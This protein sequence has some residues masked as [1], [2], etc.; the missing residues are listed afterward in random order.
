MKWTFGFYDDDD[1]IDIEYS[2]QFQSIVG[3]I[4]SYHGLKKK[5]KNKKKRKKIGFKFEDEDE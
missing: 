5:K 1:D 3:S 2:P 4:E